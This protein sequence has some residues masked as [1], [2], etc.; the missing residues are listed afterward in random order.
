VAGLSAG[1][2]SRI[3]S[4]LVGMAGG[5]KHLESIERLAGQKLTR[6]IVKKAPK[7]HFCFN[8]VLGFGTFTELVNSMLFRN[9]FT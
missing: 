3:V 6:V 2:R 9:L 8:N 5:E 1:V 7:L 4:F